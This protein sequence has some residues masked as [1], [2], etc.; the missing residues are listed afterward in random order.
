MYINV[1][2]WA[3]YASLVLQSHM[4]SKNLANCF[5]HLIH[6]YIQYLLIF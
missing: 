1:Y 4:R 5:S 2:F 6:Q 3:Q